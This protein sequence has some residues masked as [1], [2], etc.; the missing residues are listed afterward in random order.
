M[1]KKLIGF[2]FA[3]TML[4]GASMTVFAAGDTSGND[5]T[6]NDVTTVSGNSVIAGPTDITMDA[7]VT[8]P[9]LEV[10]ITSGKK[11]IANPYGLVDATLGLTADETLK[12]STIKFENKSNTAIA[13]GLLGKIQ[14]PE[15]AEGT[16]TANQVTVASS[17]STLKT[18]KTKQVFV[19]AAIYSDDTK[20]KKLQTSAG[21]AAEKALVYS[22]T[23]AK[24]TNAPI[25]AA[26][27]DTTAD[28]SSEMVLT[29]TGGT[30]KSPTSEWT[31]DDAFEVITTYDLQFGDRTKLSKFK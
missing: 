16:A 12:G 8:K 27:G 1:R 29:L 17:L 3:A 14:L 31:D 25:L 21:T 26:S 7:T 24:M 4:F 15:Y 11:V 22:K 13:V 20:A 19:Q 6:G 5:V 9:T 18:A 23:G 30:S 2:I 28:A 10:T